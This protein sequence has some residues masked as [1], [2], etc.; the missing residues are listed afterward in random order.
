MER[1]LNRIPWTPRLQGKRFW[2]VVGGIVLLLSLGLYWKMQGKATDARAPKPPAKPSVAEVSGRP[3]ALTMLQQQDRYLGR[4]RT[5]AP[6]PAPMPTTPATPAMA[7]LVVAEPPP[8]LPPPMFPAQ[9]QTA[10]PPLPPPP[11]PVTPPPTRAAPPAPPAKPKKKDWLYTKVQFSPPSFKGLTPPPGE[12]PPSVD[13][14]TGKA[15]PGSGTLVS[16]ATW[17][18]PRHPEYVWYRYQTL[19]GSMM[20]EVTSDALG[21]QVFIKVTRPLGDRFGQGI[22]FVPQESVLVAKVPS[23]VAQYGQSRLGVDVEQ[24]IFPSGTILQVDKDKVS[25]QFGAGNLPAD[26]NNHYVRLGISAILSVALS[27]GTRSVGGSGN[28][29]YQSDPALE[30]SRE[31]AA[32]ANR[33]GNKVIDRELNVAPTLTLHENMP[34]T[35]NLTRNLSL[36]DKPKVVD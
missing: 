2:Y 7:G 28:G 9:A 6:P 36:W 17:V 30:F 21:S 8:V 11:H 4:D 14:T 16:K 19:H 29:N 35:L 5:P 33:T 25:D 15:T 26:V 22:T 3:S 10:P 12:G 13:P 23:A 27:V 24:I 34:V 18:R 1:S 31:M 32:Q 20:N